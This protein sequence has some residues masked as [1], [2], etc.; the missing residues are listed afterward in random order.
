MLDLDHCDQ[1]KR[2]E[3][4]S[5]HIRKDQIYSSETFRGA[6]KTQQLV[7]GRH[8]SIDVLRTDF[9]SYTVQLGRGFDPIQHA[10]CIL[11]GRHLHFVSEIP[12]PT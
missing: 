10:G 4:Y 11:I 12:G 9:I 1:F 3:A 6:M 5:I 2:S 8:E 7:G